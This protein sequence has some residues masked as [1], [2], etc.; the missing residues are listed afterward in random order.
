M[1]TAPNTAVTMIF[2]IFISCFKMIRI[3][4]WLRDDIPLKGS[5]VSCVYRHY[6]I[7]TPAYRT[8]IDDDV[9]S[10]CSAQCIVT[11]PAVDFAFVLVPI[12]HAEPQIADDDII[13]I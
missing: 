10:S 4:Q 3:I 1:F 12:A 11:S 9:I 13:S 7:S 8:M 5:A 6:F 2:K